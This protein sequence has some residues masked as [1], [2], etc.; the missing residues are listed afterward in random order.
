MTFP[1]DLARRAPAQAQARP[2]YVLGLL[3]NTVLPGSGFTFIGRWGWHL[4]WV[5]VMYAVFSLSLVLAVSGLP[6]IFAVPLLGLVGLL[7]HY[8]F[9][10]R[11]QV[12]R[13]FQPP[14]QTPVKLILILG[15]AFLG[16]VLTGMLGA[17]LIP[18]LLGA[19][20]RALQAGEQA[21]ARRVQLQ[22]TVAQLDGT[23]K[24]GVCPLETLS[25]DERATVERC[26]VE[27]TTAN[28]LLLT[29][30]FT[31]GRTVSLP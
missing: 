28:D 26:T 24:T 31:S 1:E 27:T 22:A 17:V 5:L 11:Q 4:G 16:V 18:N 8:H 23:L 9:V 19:R 29:V 14:L 21:I 3:L 30:E 25:A 13:D 6:V 12:A 15:H 2:G 20:T 7:L 10:Y